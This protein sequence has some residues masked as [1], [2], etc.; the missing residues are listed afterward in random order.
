ME[1]KEQIN[2]TTDQ[3][4][5]SFERRKA[6][7]LLDL[8]YA[9]EQFD[10]MVVYLAGGGLTLTVAFVKD[11]ISFI[12]PS[13]QNM[14]LLKLTWIGFVL[15]LLANLFSHRSSLRSMSL[16]IK[17]EEKKSDR[18]DVITTRLNYSSVFFVISSIILFLTF[19]LNI[20]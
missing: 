3:A 11:I 13:E 8:D 1:T 10:K 20:L 18:W 5:D 2:N 6:K 16:F 14:V 12:H 7:A 15:A 17:K 9:Q 19:V 4:T